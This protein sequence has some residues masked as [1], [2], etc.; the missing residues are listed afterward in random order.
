MKKLTVLALLTVLTACSTSQNVKGIGAG[1]DS[2]K[3]SPCACQIIAQPNYGRGG[4]GFHNAGRVE[5]RA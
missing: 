3:L 2:Y 5:K 4:Y 1:T